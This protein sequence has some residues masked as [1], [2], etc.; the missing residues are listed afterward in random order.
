MFAPRPHPVR[1]LASGELIPLLQITP[2]KTDT[3]RLLVI[4]PPTRRCTLTSPRSGTASHRGTARRRSVG[5]LRRPPP[6][7]N[8]PTR[9]PQLP[10][11]ARGRVAA[12]PEP[13]AKAVRFATCNLVEVAS[14]ELSWLANFNCNETQA[15]VGKNTKLLM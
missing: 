14:A 10:G 7:Q 6:H 5:E 13:H 2:S 11:D 15:G 9:H 4:P 3:E 8:R 1:L 12:A